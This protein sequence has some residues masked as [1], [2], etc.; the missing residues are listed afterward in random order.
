MLSLG[1]HFH[2]VHNPTF[3]NLK[4]CCLSFYLITFFPCLYIPHRTKQHFYTRVFS[5]LRRPKIWIMQRLMLVIVTFNGRTAPNDFQFS[6]NPS[7][8]PAGIIYDPLKGNQN[9]CETLLSLPLMMMLMTAKIMKSNNVLPVLMMNS[10]FANS[11]GMMPFLM[12]LMK[13]DSSV[14]RDD[15]VMATMMANNRGINTQNNNLMHLMLMKALMGDR[16]KNIDV[17][18][19]KATCICNLNGSNC[20]MEWKMSLS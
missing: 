20:K 6:W 2:I 4:L 10:C 5:D 17:P 13:D 11:S 3:S 14:S 18:N 19:L 15:L 7:H 8:I 16:D 1:E 12:A 9:Q